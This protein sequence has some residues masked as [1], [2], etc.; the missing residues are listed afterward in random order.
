MKIIVTMK[1]KKGKETAV[2]MAMMTM[3]SPVVE[4]ME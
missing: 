1:K 4:E 2:V 3:T